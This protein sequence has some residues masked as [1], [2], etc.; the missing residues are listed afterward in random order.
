MGKILKV[1][2]G[3]SPHLSEPCETFCKTVFKISA[4]IRMF[5]T[6]IFCSGKILVCSFTFLVFHLILVIVMFGLYSI[7]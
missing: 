5:I 7:F 4:H 6:M 3:P 2:C 1:V